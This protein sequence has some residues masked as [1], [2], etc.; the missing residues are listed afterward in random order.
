MTEEVFGVGE[1]CEILRYDDLCHRHSS[2]SSKLKS[3]ASC[4]INH[5]HN[6]NHH[7]HHHHH[8]HHQAS[9]QNGANMDEIF[10][11]ELIYSLICTVV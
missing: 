2:P 4:Q 3:H 7:Y 11:A 6:H 10:V 1:V 5:H 8:N 9:S